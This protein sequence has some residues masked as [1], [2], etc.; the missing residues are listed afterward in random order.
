MCQPRSTWSDSKCAKYL[1]LT[2][3]K[4]RSW[5]QTCWKGWRN[6]TQRGRRRWKDRQGDCQQAAICPGCLPCCLGLGLLVCCL[7]DQETLPQPELKCRRESTTV[8]G[9]RTRRT[10]ASRTAWGCSCFCPAADLA[11]VTQASALRAGCWTF[12]FFLLLSS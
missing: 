6:R 4:M 7:N 5:L 8:E 2:L 9:E 12:S 3:F 11:A 1:R 10:S